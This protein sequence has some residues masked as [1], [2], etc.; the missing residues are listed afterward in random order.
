MANNTYINK[1]TYGGKTLVDMTDNVTSR[2]CVVS[3]W[4]FQLRTGE[5]TTGTLLSESPKSLT[6]S[7]VLYDSDGNSILDS[8]GAAISGKVIYTRS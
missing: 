4:K 3:G 7:E 6:Y 8:S 2:N 5:T 1:I